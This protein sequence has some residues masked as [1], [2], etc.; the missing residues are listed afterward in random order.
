M[1]TISVAELRQNPTAAIEDV[2][3]GET[4]VVTRH[5]HPVARLTPID[6]DAVQIIPPRNP[7][8]P[9]LADRKDLPRKSVAEVEALIRE[10]ASDR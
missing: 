8:A 4:Y 7:R 3:N 2:A 9:K 10:M 6:D 1:K 5:K